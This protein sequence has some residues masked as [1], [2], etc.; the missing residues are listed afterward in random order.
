[1]ESW[2][3]LSRTDLTRLLANTLWALR[4]KK[5]EQGHGKELL[6]GPIPQTIWLTAEIRELMEELNKIATNPRLE[7]TYRNPER[8]PLTSSRSSTSVS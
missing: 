2:E 3:R 6:H 4:R 8:K 1:M 5:A 7:K